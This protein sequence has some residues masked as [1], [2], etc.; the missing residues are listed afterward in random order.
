MMRVTIIKDDN[1][2]LIDG[3]GYGNLDLSFMDSTIHAVQWYDTHGEIERKDPVTK[4]MTSNEEIS[5][6]DEFQPAIDAWQVKK[7]EIAARLTSEQNT[8]Q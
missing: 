5:S 8:S 1:S 7:D 2:V 6:F 4:R 3:E